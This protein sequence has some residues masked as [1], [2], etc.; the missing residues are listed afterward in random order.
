LNKEVEKYLLEL[1]AAGKS[2]DLRKSSERNLNNLTL[3]LME[4]FFLKSWT[5]VEE[6]HLNSFLIYL[7]KNTGQKNSSLRQAVSRI[8]RFFRWIYQS[9]KVLVNIAEN[10]R[11]PK[12][13]HT[14]PH[15]LSEAEISCIIEQPDTEKT[16]GVRD[17]AIMETLYATGIRHGELYKLNVRD[18]DG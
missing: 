3:Y 9:N 6:T 16:I 15:V 12:A 14:L 11:L 18:F 4:A 13:G 1:E 7:W 17:R 5:Q 2:R 10:F 8:R